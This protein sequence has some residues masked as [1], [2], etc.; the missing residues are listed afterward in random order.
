MKISN[1]E[2]SKAKQIVL[3]TNNF[4]ISHMQRQLEIS[5]TKATAIMKLI[6]LK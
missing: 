5:Y 6:K 3:Q 1:H 2:I 4:S